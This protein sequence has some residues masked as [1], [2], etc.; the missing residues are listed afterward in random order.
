[1]TIK[2]YPGE[3]R[4]PN[5][6]SPLTIGNITLRNRIMQSAHAKAF[7]IRDGITNN[8]DI[9]YHAARAKGGIGLMITGN[10]LVHPTSNTF[11]RGFSYGYRKEMVERDAALTQIVHDFGAHIFAQLLSLA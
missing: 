8:R 4:Y 7:H 10:R 1:M 5:L 9:F 2:T 11:C 6:F 3:S